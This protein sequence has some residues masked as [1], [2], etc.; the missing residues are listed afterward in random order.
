MRRA[1]LIWLAIIALVFGGVA[2]PATAADSPADC[3]TG[4]G[5]DELRAMPIVLRVQAAP[6]QWQPSGPRSSDADPAAVVVP[7]WHTLRL[8]PDAPASRLVPIV[9][10]DPEAPGTGA[11]LG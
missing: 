1:A 9:P 2:L 7:A 4:M 3:V 5:G 10:S 11:V 8:L 6:G